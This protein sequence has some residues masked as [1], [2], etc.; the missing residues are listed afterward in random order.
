VTHV[1]PPPS[2]NRR[3]DWNAV[4][5]RMHSTIN[6]LAKRGW[7]V[8]LDTPFKLLNRLHAGLKASNFE[9]V[10]G[11]M[12]AY[13]SLQLKEIKKGCLSRH[14][15]RARVLAEAFRAHERKQYELSIPVFLAQADGI[16]VDLLGVKFYARSKGIPATAAKARGL[17][18]DSVSDAI[19]EP[20]RHA[21]ALNAHE[22]EIAPA[23]GILNRHKVL[24]GISNDYASESNGLRAISLV[25]YLSAG[26]AGLQRLKEITPEQIEATK[27]EFQA[28]AAD[29]VR[30]QNRSWFPAMFM[31]FQDR[32][33]ELFR[34]KTL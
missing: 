11:L 33:R 13:I 1:Q 5:L 7:Y 26:V 6:G 2:S 8:D 23:S 32:F 9:H 30:Y 25:N 21:G 27:R 28:I 14:P 18:M 15:D 24:H 20:L 22:K 10:D 4:S 3:I 12:G 34:R 31:L 17:E 19:L 29:I 16:C